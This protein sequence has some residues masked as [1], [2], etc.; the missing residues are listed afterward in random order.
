MKREKAQTRRGDDAEPQVKP[1]SLVPV[2][3]Y[4]G[5]RLASGRLFFFFQ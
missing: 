3:R 1:E 5:S 4:H 2:S